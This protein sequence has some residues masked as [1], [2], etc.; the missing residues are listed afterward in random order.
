M[1]KTHWNP[2]HSDY[3]DQLNGCSH[4][5]TSHPNDTVMTPPSNGVSDGINW[6]VTEGMDLLGY[7]TRRRPQSE[8][9]DFYRNYAQYMPGYDV[10]GVPSGAIAQDRAT[11]HVG[12]GEDADSPWTRIRDSLVRQEAGMIE[13]RMARGE[14]P[15]LSF[16]DLYDA[17][18]TA[19][20]QSGGG[21]NQFIDP[22][23][24]ALAVYGAP[25]MELFGIDAGPLTGAS[26]DIFNDPT[27]SATEGW[28]KR[29]A[30]NGG[31]M[32][33][34]AAMMTNP[35]TMLPGMGLMG[36]GAFG[37]AYNTASAIFDG[38]MLGEWGDA[39]SSGAGA[40]WDGITSVGSG[41][42]EGAGDLW[43]GATGAL[44]DA[45]SAVGSLF[46]W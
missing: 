23:S 25:A 4:P 39:I 15:S 19:Y 2:E 46:S 8:D 35:L 12:H 17:H 16:M 42:A 31:E 27:D 44:G 11:N 36:L 3:L 45:A 28:L 41:I 32:A 10:N 22:G 9:N 1:C 33:A 13:D 26:I 30:L 37:A 21:G 18:Y 24:F 6:A 40:A 5:Q 34:G 14:D 38:G 20:N 7:D 29:M 43:D